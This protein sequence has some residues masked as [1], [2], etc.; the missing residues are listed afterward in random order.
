MEQ[1]DLHPGL[2][3]AVEHAHVGDHALVSVEIGIEPQRLQRRRARGLG[4]RNALDNRLQN[5]VDADALLGA[6]Q[7]G[8]VAGNG[9]DVL[10]LLLR[11][12]DVGVR[13]I[14]LVDDGDDGQVLLHRQVHVG[15]RLRLDALRRVHD[16]QRPFARAQAARHLVGEIHV[17]RRIDQVQLVSLAIL[18]L[19]RHR[20]RVRLDGDAA[21]P[22]QV[23]RIEQLVLHVAR[24]DGAGPVQQPV[25]KRR[26]PMI[27]MGDDAEISYM[28]CVHY[29]A[30]NC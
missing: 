9:Q 4:R 2:Q 10:Q 15:H 23:H 29:C 1:F 27:N 7:N 17:P 6:G 13:Q 19:V 18:R 11:Q 16:E 24:G 26:L 30:L 3:L 14:D 21:L 25:G 28:R 8:R 20:D 12:R 5:L 22:F